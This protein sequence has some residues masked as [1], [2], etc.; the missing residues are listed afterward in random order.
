MSFLVL[1]VNQRVVSFP[2]RRVLY[3]VGVTCILG[4]TTSLTHLPGL[5]TQQEI[6]PSGFR[7]RGLLSTSDHIKVRPIHLFHLSHLKQVSESF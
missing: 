3:V 5:E 2:D 1:L 4:F 6:I 7:S